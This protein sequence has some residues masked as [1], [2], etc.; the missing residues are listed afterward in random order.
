VQ[1]EPEAGP[2]SRAKPNRGR[3]AGP[4][5]R[6]AL[7]N[8]ARDV[9]AE[10]GL[11]APLSVIARRAGVGQGSLYRHFPDR[12]GLA[13]AVFDDN[14]AELEALAARPDAHLLDLIDGVAGQA[15]RSGALIELITAE[16]D[17]PRAEHLR[18]RLAAVVDAMLDR[19]RQGSAVADGLTT[20]DVMLAI[21]MLALLL[22]QTDASEQSHVADR[23]RR[24]LR[25]GSPDR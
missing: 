12:I 7:I 4:G 10:S 23:A 14:I 8:A 13:V 16:R 18:T 15:M 19:D 2:E 1:A 9:F 24:L 22:A 3:A 20:E 21:A 17:D 5:N 6:Q 25:L 11:G